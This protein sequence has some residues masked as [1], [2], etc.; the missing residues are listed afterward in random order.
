M[1][2]WVMYCGNAN[3]ACGT[4]DWNGLVVG[5]TYKVVKTVYQKDFT[6]YVLA[7]RLSDEH[8]DSTLFSEPVISNMVTNPYFNYCQADCDTVDT[9]E[10]I[11][12]DHTFCGK[13]FQVYCD[14]TE[15]LLRGFHAKEE[16]PS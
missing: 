11:Y 2:K 4:T 3:L 8:F 7:E 1:A 14:G 12:E 16:M 6:F 5:V 10:L 13:I 15:L 9:F